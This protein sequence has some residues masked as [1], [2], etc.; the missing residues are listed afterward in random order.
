MTETSTRQRVVDLLKEQLLAEVRE[1]IHSMV[2]FGSVARGDAN[3]ESDIDIIVIS[4]ASFEIKQRVHHISSDI[5][6]EHGVFTQLVFF[7]TQGF[8]KEIRMRSWF[9]MD[10]VSQGI[11][12]HDDGTYR[13]SVKSCV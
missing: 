5:D 3:A 8:E 11:V 4:D 6:L 10:V 12:L 7:K 1:H 13:G 2:L 9:S